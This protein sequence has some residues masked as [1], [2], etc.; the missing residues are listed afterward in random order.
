MKNAPLKKI[1]TRENIGRIFSY[2]YIDELK[3]EHKFEDVKGNSY[4]KLLKFLIREGYLDER[5]SYYMAYFYENSL[6]KVDKNFL[7]AVA[8]KEKLEYGYRLDNPNLVVERLGISDFDE[9]E[10]LNFDLL[11]CLLK[12]EDNNS[13]N[14]KTTIFTQLKETK[15]FEFVN[16]YLKLDN[17][18]EIYRKKFTMFLYSIWETFFSEAKNYEKLLEND[19]YMYV[20]DILQFSKK[21][22]LEIINKNNNI[23]EYIE[24]KKD[25][26]N[27]NLYAK[28]IK[29]LEMQ[30]NH[31]NFFANL[32]GLDIKFKELE[33][34][35]SFD[36]FSRKGLGWAIFESNFKKK[37]YILNF[38][39]INLIIKEV[40]YRDILY[41]DIQRPSKFEETLSFLKDKKMSLTDE[42]LNELNNILSRELKVKNYTIIN[43]GLENSSYLLDYLEE[44]M[45]KYAEIILENCDGKI[46]E[47]EEYIIK[48]LN[49]EDIIDER[50]QKYIEF[51]ANNITDFSEINNRN[52]WNIFL[53]KKKAE[54]SEKNIITYF[55]ENGFNEIL[56]KFINLKLKKLSYKEFNFE[57]EDKSM[58][59]IEVL[60]CYELDNEVYKNILE[61]LEYNKAEIIFPENIPEEKVDILIKLSIIKMNPDNLKFIRSYYQNNLNNFIKSNLENYIK[62]I[63]IYNS[64][65]PQE[66]LLV[67]LSDEKIDVDSKLK[68]LSFSNQKIKIMNK[69]YPAKVQNYILENNY[70][71]SEFLEL[72]ENF[73]NFEEKTKE[74]I[75]DIIKDNI[76]NFYSNLDKAPSSLINKFLKN[77]EI[78]N[79]IKLTILINLLNFIKEIETFYKHLKLV[80][81]KDYKNLVKRNTSFNISINEFNLQLL[82]KLKEKGF[83]EKF[84]QIDETTYEVITVKDKEKLID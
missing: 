43:K 12:L 78:D 74:I 57:E 69:D 62:I 36:A 19:L 46:E 14:K 38:N 77:K 68:L 9:I 30:L 29:I 8:D 48:F 71:S 17:L 67:I 37:R 3:N 83:I 75:F 34:S 59:F 18:E 13:K 52:L 41:K 61:T 56:I 10:S 65:F 49:F 53:S 33:Y 6:T 2:T 50:K 51:L 35:D 11:N 79:A 54:Y 42:K 45:D 76:N 20:V 44:N 4:F 1:I 58:F 7:I 63:E 24:N 22:D 64:L 39:N 23:I 55:R 31:S 16:S 5:Y 15:N 27:F 26:F 60:K 84:S 21:D 82:E 70:D 81:S 40:L 32:E 73:N 28:N 80:N 47:E 25:F 72:M 66:E